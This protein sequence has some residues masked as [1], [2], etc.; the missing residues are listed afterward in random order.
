MKDVDGI[1]LGYDITRRETFEEVKNRWYPMVKD[2][3]DCNL[4]Y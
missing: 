4:I 1:V 2:I 3:S